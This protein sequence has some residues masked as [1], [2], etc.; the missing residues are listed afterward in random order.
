MRAG[1]QLRRVPSCEHRR[2]PV[3][4]I[5]MGFFPSGPSTPGYAYCLSLLD[6]FTALSRHAR[7]AMRSIS[8]ALHEFHR[9][10]NFVLR[11]AHGMPVQEGYR[12]TLQHTLQ[13]YGVM[14]HGIRHNAAAFVATSTPPDGGNEQGRAG[15]HLHGDDLVHALRT[16]PT[17]PTTRRVR[18]PG[19]PSIVPIIVDTTPFQSLHAGPPP[20]SP[21]PHNQE[22]APPRTP[23][24]VRFAPTVPIGAEP[25]YEVA[26]QLGFDPLQNTKIHESL[27]ERCPACFNLETVGR[28]FDE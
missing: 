24:R 26:K 27:I 9:S 18:P 22:P 10:R 4:L 15:E 21:T 25:W 7:T 20:P 28:S 1:F 11:G 13:W 3:I 14:M 5:E 19:R 12:R 2:L 6:F 23:R 16:P 8:A 17:T